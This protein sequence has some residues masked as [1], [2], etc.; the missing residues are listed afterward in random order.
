MTFQKRKNTGPSKPMLLAAAIVL[1]MSPALSAQAQ[2]ASGEREPASR[3]EQTYAF[4]I[5]PQALPQALVDFSSVTGIQVLYT[6]NSASDH[7]VPELEGEYTAADALR[8]LLAG[9][10][11]S[12]RF[13]GD[14]SITIEKATQS[15]T[16][17]TMLQAIEVLGRGEQT[18]FA[19]TTFS[20][21]KT[22]THVLDV[23][24]ALSVT[25]KEVIEEQNIVQLNDIAP[26]VAGVNEFSVYDDLTIRGFRNQDDRRVN[27]LRV[28]NNFWSQPYIANV[29]RVEVLKGPS[30]VLYG[31]ASPGGVVNIVTKKPLAGRRQEIRADLGTFGSGDN[32]FLGAFDTTG[33]VNESGTLLYRFNASS[34]DQD[35]FRTEIGDKGYQ[36]A[37]SLSWV[38]NEDTR[39]NVELSYV[40]R[41]S[42]LD[43]GQP[44]LADSSTLGIIPIDVSV[45]QPGDRLDFQDFTATV[46]LDQALSN[47]WR[48]AAALQYH[49]YDEQLNEH[50]LS[51]N[52]PSGSE[53]NVR[54]IERETEAETLSGT[55]YA[56]GQL[57]TGDLFHKLVVGVDALDQ[58]EESRNFTVED[59][60]VFDVLDPVNI[61]RP[62][63][64]YALTEPAYSP[65]GEDNTRTGVFVQDQITLGKWDFLAGLRY[66]RFSTRP[67][68]G[69][70][71]SESDVSPRLGTVYR[72]SE[73]LS[74]YG[75]YAEGF[76]PNFG[77]TALEGGP[78]D[79]TT[80]R[81]FEVGAKQLAFD[82]DLLFTAALYR[83]INDDIV[84]YADDVNNPDLYRQRGQEQATGLELEA[85]GQVSDRLSVIANYAYNDAEI[86]E[87]ELADNE[88]KTKE[89]A[90]RHTATVW[91]KYRIGAGF[92]VGAGAE[93]V[94]DRKTFE[95][96]FELPDYTI[97]NAG[98]FYERG[99]LDVSLMGR[100]LTDEDHWTGGYYPGRLYPGNP[101]QVT[102]SAR[103]AF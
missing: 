38:P 97:Y 65:F 91:G 30:A 1:S 68:G 49:S 54:Y 80:S 56:T 6:E 24:Q 17:P 50:R 37:P 33:P 92:S 64:T 81:L 76:E 52:L 31:Q 32:Q 40:D 19:E 3:K 60:F 73:S 22:E 13:T 85:V 28:Y 44:N 34:W 75:T 67:L 51:T 23:P 95:P 18:D 7:I 27:G 72:L 8:E 5:S 101:L 79:P 84:V 61:R 14:D 77:F 55:L 11:L 16:A 43:R 2:E 99:G 12:M 48:L 47:N 58:N 46:S 39:V 71:F 102:M 36:L 20:A 10:G 93:Y 69:E 59:V 41:E 4:D 87:D 100:N 82:G 9:S 98:L 63:D 94:G 78:F 83:I 66:S 90:P 15:A 88:G 70:K 25:T 86:T 74:F 29:E 21:T 35:S 103:Y 42:V 57:E 96:G 53:Y 45:T 26:Y 62:V 89:G